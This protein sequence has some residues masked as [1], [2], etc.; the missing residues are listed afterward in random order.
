MDDARQHTATATAT[1][2]TTGTATRSMWEW[3]EGGVEYLVKAQSA[4]DKHAAGGRTPTYES[5]NRYAAR[6][7]W[8]GAAWRGAVVRCVG[9]AWHGMAW[10]GVVWCGMAWCGAVR[11][12]PSS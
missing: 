3:L 2:A 12:Q 1:A 11:R 7:T 6:A 4:A 10:R 9:V 5:I 8:C